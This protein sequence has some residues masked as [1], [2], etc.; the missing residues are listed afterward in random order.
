MTTI[1]TLR[2]LLVIL[3]TICFIITFSFIV[4]CR[5][6]ET[7]EVKEDPVETKE[8]TE[9][10]AE[11]PVEEVEED[12]E[13][14]ATEEMEEETSGYMDVT[15]AEAKELIENN[16]DLIIL[17]VSPRYDDGHLPGAVNYPI[18]DGSLDDAIP[19]FDS[20]A[21]YL[22]YCHSDTSSKSGAQKLIDA[23]F[24]NVY[25]LE[26]NYVAWVDAGYEVETGQA[27]EGDVAELKIVSP[28]FS[29]NEKVPVKFTCDADNINPQLDISGIP[30]GTASLVLIIDDPDAPGGTWVHW[31]VWNI[32]PAATSILENNVPSGAVEGVTDFGV[33]GY[34]GPCPPSGTHRYFF[35]IFALDIMLDL[36]SSSTASD[37]ESAIQGH[38]LDSAE[39]IGL[40][41]E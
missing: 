10:E 16:P 5:K 39:L 38:V 1:R 2:V 25:R 24:M 7:V 31:T 20:E 23:G 40:Y 30:Q 19:T 27:V 34:G 41:G 37:I 12:G 29:E 18:V 8:T 14:E 28:A 32:D 3:V 17:D 13:D 4:S 11:A 22:V 9:E 6:A 33:P 35:K 15:A 26:G 21:K 36:D